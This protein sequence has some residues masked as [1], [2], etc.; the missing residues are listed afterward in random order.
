MENTMRLKSV[1]HHTKTLTE[2]IASEDLTAELKSGLENGYAYKIEHSIDR[3]YLRDLKE[4]LNAQLNLQSENYTPRVPGC[5]NYMQNHWDHESQVV[6]AKFVSWSYFPWND[7]SKK[8]FEQIK[9]MFAL[10]NMLAGLEQGKYID[11]LDSEASARAAFQFYPRGL[12]YMA[13]HQDPYNIHQFAIPT[14]L[15]SDYGTDY[16]SGGFFAVDEQNEKFYFDQH[17]NF[18][19]LTLFHTSIPHGVEIVD[20]EKPECKSIYDGR[21]MMIAAV[22]AFSGQSKKFEAKVTSIAKN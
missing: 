5:P 8:L 22:N 13:E 18:G 11:H 15:L 3:N 4:I 10:R 6:G 17:L 2:I 9:P 7:E 19:D 20:K 16:V 12:G 14:L 21:L 1:I